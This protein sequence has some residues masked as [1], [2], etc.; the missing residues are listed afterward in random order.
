MGAVFGVA[1]LADLALALYPFSFGSAGWEFGT[2]AAVMNNL[3]LA[4]VGVGFVAAAGFARSATWIIKT[5]GII[6]AL[7]LAVVLAM[8]VMFSRN[9]GE[10]VRSVTDPILREGLK[11]SI[12]RT[13]VQ[14]LAYLAVFGWLVAKTRRA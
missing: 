2:A 13:A 9:L 8:A 4:A 14:L 6:S 7:F 10:A 1:S 3:P 5:A 12:V 11:E